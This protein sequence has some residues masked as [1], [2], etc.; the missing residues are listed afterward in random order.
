M[1]PAPATPAAILKKSMSDVTSSVERACRILRSLSEPGIGR[2]TEIANATDLDKTTVLRLLD[3][4]TRD[5]FVRRDPQTKRY[6]LGPELLVLGSAALKRFDP[7]P[8]VQPSLWRLAGTF[9]DSVILSIPS[10]V[11]SLCAD[12]VEGTFPIRA[13]YLAV[14][15]RRPLGV[16]AGSLALLAW[17]ADDERRAALEIIGPQLRRYPKLNAKLLERYALEARERGYAVM[18][19]AVVDRMG[20]IAA[21]LMGPDGRPV[22]AISIAALT[23]R[24][25]SREAALGKALQRECAVCEVLWRGASSGAAPRRTRVVR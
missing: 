20:G 8:F 25:V 17:I 21:P 4:L 22:A 1:P 11:E 16:G 19:D 23:E 5:G 7:R 9:E 15:S 14:G 18:L 12:V 2:L 24:I 3:V 10:G 13:N 6:A